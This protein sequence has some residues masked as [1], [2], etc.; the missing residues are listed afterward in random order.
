MQSAARKPSSR[1][2]QSSA[3]IKHAH[4]MAEG[5]KA[6]ET[7]SSTD[8]NISNQRKSGKIPVPIHRESLSSSNLYRDSQDGSTGSD[9]SQDDVS[10]VKRHSYNPHDPLSAKL[11]S[12]INS[13]SNA[14]KMSRSLSR[15]T[16]TEETLSR[17]EGYETD[18]H[19]SKYPT[20]AQTG[21]E[22][23]TNKSQNTMTVK[24][25]PTPSAPPCEEMFGKTGPNLHASQT[26]K[27]KDSKSPK[28]KSSKIRRAPKSPGNDKFSLSKNPQQRSVQS[29]ME[30]S[31]ST[32]MQKNSYLSLQL[33]KLR[34]DIM[35]VNYSP[36]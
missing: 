21:N 25:E 28:S 31:R 19:D 12:I 11:S 29:L 2:R 34:D 20:N 13:A 1:S 27:Y 6:R 33:K 10:T 16:Y 26:Q 24:S 5:R 35:D 8:V 22:I 23:I 7:S 17:E 9:N 14:P 18:D 3:E 15:E 32:E 4:N 36:G 30:T